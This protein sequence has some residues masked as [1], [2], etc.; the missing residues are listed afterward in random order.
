M[1]RQLAAQLDAFVLAENA[2]ARRE[3]LL[4]IRPCVIKLLGQTAL[5]ESKVALTLAVTKDVDVFSDY[6]FAVEREFRRLLAL[7]GL[8]LDPLGGEVWMPR[9]TVYQALFAGRFVTLLVAEVEAVLVS[10]GLK[11]P[12]KNG[13]LLT[14]YLARGAS[15]RFVE[16]ARKYQLDLEQFL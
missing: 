14:E 12:R 7:Q 11:A 2:A 16:L 6:E 4:P 5:L 8:D 10:K 13:P 1:L 9:E 15:S 3:G